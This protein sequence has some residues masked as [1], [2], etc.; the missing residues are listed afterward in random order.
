MRKCGEFKVSVS[1][2]TG[3]KILKSSMSDRESM[4]GEEG[5]EKGLF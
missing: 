5:R 1:N 3:G 2:P 4:G